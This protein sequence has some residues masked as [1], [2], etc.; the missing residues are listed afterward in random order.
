L[1][2]VQV[3]SFAS[4]AGNHSALSTKQAILTRNAANAPTACKTPKA[5]ANS[6]PVVGACDNPGTTYAP[7]RQH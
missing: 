4:I 5:F 3:F 2:A 1:R 6:S 7:V